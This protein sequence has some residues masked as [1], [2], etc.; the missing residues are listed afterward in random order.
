MDRLTLQEL[1]HLEGEAAIVTGG[2]QGIGRAIGV[3]LA[4]AGAS[5]MIADVDAAA[6]EEAAVAIRSAGGVAQSCR[7]DARSGTDAEAVVRAT[8]EA[9]GGL[10]LLVNNAGVFPL[11]PVLDTSE[12]VWDRVLD[13]NLKGAFL[14][15]Q[16]AARLMAVTGAGGRIVNIAS[17]DALHPNGMA[18][19]Y[20]ASKGGLLMLT[21]ALALE[22]A[23]FG[24]RV[25]AVS[26]GGIVTPGS[27]SA[28][29]GL[30]DK[31]GLEEEQIVQGWV[32]RVP[33]G[34]M[35]EPDDVARVVLFLASRAAD[36]VTGENLLVDGGYLLS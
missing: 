29:R 14:Y 1:F 18:A 11:V 19:H 35:G 23:G 28:R 20:N 36:Y 12:E 22:L 33:L 9:F 30:C 21:K 4:E 31:L 5:V 8:Q 2:A 16:A 24:I 15:A 26:P 3:R 6:A 34:R 17:I 10:T 7:A 27:A 13:T 25:N 32:R